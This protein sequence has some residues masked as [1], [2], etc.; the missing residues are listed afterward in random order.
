MSGRF[1]VQWKGKP[2]EDATWE[3]ALNIQSQFPEFRLEDKSVS[4]EGGTARTSNV[5]MGPNGLLP[6]PKFWKVYTR[7]IKRDQKENDDLARSV[8][9]VTMM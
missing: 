6:M 8:G 5:G 2:I 3:D 7:R 1:L 9:R 4:R